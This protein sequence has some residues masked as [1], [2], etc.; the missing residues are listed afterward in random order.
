MGFTALL[1]VAYIILLGTDILVFLQ[2]R[3]AAGIS[4]LIVIV[5]SVIAFGYAWIISPM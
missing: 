4:L 1:A 5:I 3:K 2:N